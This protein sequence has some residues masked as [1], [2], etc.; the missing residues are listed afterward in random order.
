MKTEKIFAVVTAYHKEHRDVILRAVE[1]VKRMRS[2]GYQV[3]HYLV[4]DGHPQDFSAASVHHIQLPTE[5]RDYGDTPRLIGATLAIRE[6]CHGLM[7][8]D[9]DNVVY[10]NHLELA[11]QKYT[12]ESNNIVLTKRDFLRPNGEKITFTCAEDQNFSHVDT[13]CFVFFDE[14]VYEALEWIKI[15]SKL[16]AFGDRYFWNLLRDSRNTFGAT[17]TPTVGYTCLWAGVYH[18]INEAPP[19]G[20]KELDW[21]DMEDFWD[22]LSEKDLSILKNRLKIKNPIRLQKK[23]YQNG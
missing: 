23:D 22:N 17:E 2:A 7:F 20:A 10:P 5:H 19:P 9:A 1:S 13:G 15:P 6:G 18:E 21:S 12:H 11:L 14:A 16:S 3:K 8:L 4:A